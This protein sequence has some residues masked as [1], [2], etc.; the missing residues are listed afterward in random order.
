MAEPAEATEA[1]GAI[2]PR[3]GAWNDICEL[4]LQSYVADLDAKGYCIVPPE[5][6]NPNNLSG[7]LLEALLNVAERRNGERPDVVTGATHAYKPALLH[8]YDSAR[9]G[10][11]GTEIEAGK[12]EANPA[13][14]K[15]DD[16]VDSPFGDGMALIFNEDEVFAEAVMNP[17]LVA[18]VT[19]LVGYSAVLSSM[20][21]WMKG[22]CRSNFALHS[23]SGLP[24]PLPAQAYQAQCTYVLTDF[25]RENGAT[26]IVPGSH[27]WC[28]KPT[29]HEATLKLYEEGGR[30]QAVVL[31][32]P[33]GSLILW[34]GN[35][36]HGAFNRVAPGLRV[37]M[38]VYF[39]RQFIRPLEDYVG[40]VPQKL[41][42]RYGPRFAM[43]LQQGC[44]PGFSSQGERVSF[45]ARAEEVVSAYK[46]E[47][48]IALGSKNDPYN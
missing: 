40:R 48:G 46:Q 25:D 41:L 39:V 3:E 29:S 30:D 37:S 35:T 17:P 44:V 38:T 7:R 23:D 22:P 13:R 24:N 34:H 28:R 16:A 6:A 8:G 20:G 12:E 10:K 32:A 21:C 11:D 31:E 9:Y 19:Y 27:K 14:L 18:L 26:C 47:S 15:Q 43:L 42:D 4:G 33:P 36:W 45:T 1:L 5:I 2:E